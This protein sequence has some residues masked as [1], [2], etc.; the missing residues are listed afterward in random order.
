MAFAE[1]PALETMIQYLP[2]GGADA[3]L[4]IGG[5]TSKCDLSS[6]RASKR[7]VIFLFH[8]AREYFFP[9]FLVDE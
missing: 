9:Q 5:S 7:N 8:E 1:K 3:L 2:S 6:N 4:L